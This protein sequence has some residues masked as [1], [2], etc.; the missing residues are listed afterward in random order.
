[1]IG[2]IFFIP[3]SFLF[4]LILLIEEC[5]YD[6]DIQKHF[7]DQKKYQK[8]NKY[9][10]HTGKDLLRKKE[11]HSEKKQ[12]YKLFHNLVYSTLPVS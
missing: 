9:T 1:M 10:C 2:T 7:N 5:Y 12:E 11:D 4:I 8:Y 6:I 3:L